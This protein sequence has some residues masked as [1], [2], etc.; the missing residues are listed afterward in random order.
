ME[1]GCSLPFKDCNTYGRG[2]IVAR[3]RVR[4]KQKQKKAAGAQQR[5]SLKAEMQHNVKVH[6]ATMSNPTRKSYMDSI[7]QFDQWR[8]AVGISNREVR[9][10]PREAVIRWRASL[11]QEIPIEYKGLLKLRRKQQA[12]QNSSI[13]TKIAG[14]CCGLGIDMHGI[15][16]TPTADQKIKSS[17][18]NS[19]AEKARKKAE[20]QRIVRFAELV[21]GRKAAYGRLT[22]ADFVKDESGYCCV[23]FIRDKGG[24]TQLQRIAPENMEEVNAYFTGKK[25]DELIFPERI[26]HDLDLH[27]IRAEHA[28][29]EYAR[30][31]KICSTPAGREQMRKELWARFR[32]P[33]IGN[34]TWLAAQK[35]LRDASTE[36]NRREALR[37]IAR[38]EKKFANELKDGVY[39]LRGKNRETA[40]LHSRPAEYDRLALCCVSVFALSHWRNEV[41]V[42]HYM[43]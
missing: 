3:G 8:K 30:Y 23:R 18:L 32:D 29:A 25:K 39:I 28:R 37:Q 43:I 27:A 36:K 15:T 38:Q 24:K 22:G 34:A 42:K 2:K 19:R 35:R 11:M 6:T 31:A 13:K 5:C 20:N 16:K 7:L 33:V 10:N 21:G 4:K 41:T 26:N 1:G 40:I 12:Y 9:E 17:G 14:V